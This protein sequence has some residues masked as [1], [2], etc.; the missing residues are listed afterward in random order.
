M[1]L[2]I[3]KAPRTTAVSSDFNNYAITKAQ[4][5][6]AAGSHAKKIKSVDFDAGGFTVW[7]KASFDF[8][9]NESGCAGFEFDSEYDLLNLVKIDCQTIKK[10]S[11]A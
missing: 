11:H 4:V 8:G 2:V 9:C 10:I 5:L 3:I 1:S 6:Q 7:L